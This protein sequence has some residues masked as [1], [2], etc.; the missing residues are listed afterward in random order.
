MTQVRAAALYAGLTLP[1]AIASHIAAEALA[2]H[3]SVLSVAASP[4]HAYLGAIAVLCLAVTGGILAAGRYEVRRLGGLLANDLPFKGQGLRFFAAS[5]A[6]QFGFAGI[7]L[8]GEGTLDAANALVALVA[9]AIAS[10]I[11]SALLALVRERLRHIS[12]S[13]FRLRIFTARPVPRR[14]FRTL[15]GPYFAYVPVRGNRPPPLR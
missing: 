8:F 7:T 4:L 12:F 10:L 2:L 14:S 15:S 9:V 6:V 5:M 11:T 3:Q 1:L 13:G